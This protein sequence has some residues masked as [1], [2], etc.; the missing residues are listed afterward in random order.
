MVSSLTKRLRGPD[1]MVRG[2]D[3]SRGP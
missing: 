3:L 1:E 2:P